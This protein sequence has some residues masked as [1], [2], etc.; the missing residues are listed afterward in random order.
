MHP[1]VRT[2]YVGWWP[3]YTTS[4]AWFSPKMGIHAKTGMPSFRGK[5]VSGKFF[6]SALKLS[7]NK[8]GCS[9][10]PPFGRLTML[11]LHIINFNCSILI[12]YINWLNIFWIHRTNTWIMLLQK[13][14]THFL[15]WQGR[16][17]LV[18]LCFGFAVVRAAHGDDLQTGPTSVDK[19][20]AFLI[21]IWNCCQIQQVTTC[22][23]WSSW[24]FCGYVFVCLTIW[25]K[26]ILIHSP[27]SGSRTWQKQIT[28][29]GR[30]RDKTSVF[31]LTTH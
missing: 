29:L 20:L 30:Q 16:F 17:G 14:A 8:N 2:H 31:Q 24:R 19:Q 11:I 10:V 3:M 23:F 27:H 12:W 15:L 7:G 4:S 5:V 28:G 13:T 25:P 18:A 26:T 1:I 6:S 22:C 21:A 9:E